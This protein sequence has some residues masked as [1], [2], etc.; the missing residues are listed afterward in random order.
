MM[1]RMHGVLVVMDHYT[2]RVIGFGVHAGVVNGEALCR[3]FK[4]A[5]RGV[6]TFQATSA[7]IMIRCTAVINGKPISESSTS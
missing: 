4:Q 1:L 3:M 5:I 7:P 2:R 6:T